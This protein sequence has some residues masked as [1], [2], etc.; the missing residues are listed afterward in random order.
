MRKQR[1]VTRQTAQA[2]TDGQSHS[3]RLPRRRS[4]MLAGTAVVGLVMVTACGSSSGT[5][6][7]S[8]A[9]TGSKTIVIGSDLEES[10]AAGAY[11]APEVQGAQFYIDQIN[12]KG[13]VDG[14]KLALSNKDNRSTASVAVTGF[15]QLA[16]NPSVVAV[17]GPA[18][19]DTAQ[20]L[21]KLSKQEKLPLVSFL[22][23]ATDQ[24]FDSNPYWYRMAWSTNRTVSAL[25]KEVKANGGTTLGVIYPNDVGGQAGAA[26]LQA[27]SKAAGVSVVGTATYQD[28]VVD[29]TSEVLKVKASKPS[30]Y[31]VWDPD[32]QNQLGLIVR[33]MR[34]N[35]ITAPIYVPED[36]SL[37]QFVTAAGSSVSKVY[38]WASFSPT[39]PSTSVQKAF[40]TAWRGKYGSDPTDFNSAGY[41]QAQLIVTA[42]RQVLHSHRA[43]TRQTVNAALNHLKDV[44]T[45]Y[46]AVTYTPT[47]HGEP[48]AAVP[49]LEYR[50]GAS[51]QVAG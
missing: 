18:L 9:A 16:A 8:A 17:F 19:P 32:S 42:I 13:G 6:A 37:T 14:H 2:L 26:S 30:A 44:P 38:Y 5:K 49:V 48:F 31:A 51:Y 43:A 29:P 1:R 11:G 35:G 46:G 28:G 36:A 12:A 33:T 45:V 3:R 34:S 21:A 23:S 27:L 15:Q 7:T 40:T 10:G 20:L 22:L 50:N 47:N 24:A 4:L 25:L 39:H 41:A